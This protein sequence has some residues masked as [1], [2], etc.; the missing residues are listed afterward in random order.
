M[1]K[2]TNKKKLNMKIIENANKN[3][4]TQKTVSVIV[5]GNEYDI[6]IDQQF[7]TTKIE[8]MVKNYLNSENREKFNELDEGAKIGYIMFLIIR[9]FTDLEIPN[10]LKFEEEINLINSLIDLGVFEKIAQNIPESEIIK[11]NEFLQKFNENLNEII[12]N[13][14]IKGKLDGESSDVDG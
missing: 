10:N 8:K 4:F 6:I 13:E 9:E 5:D 3:Q 1:A 14:N 7:K 12:K 11:V 2:T